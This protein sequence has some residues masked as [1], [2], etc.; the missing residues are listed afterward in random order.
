M[1]E[2][3]RTLDV[4]VKELRRQQAVGMGGLMDLNDPK[5][6]RIRYVVDLEALAAAID[7]DEAQRQAE[8]NDE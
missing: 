2:R 3:S 4:I 6:A 7:A 1:T 5:Q 8:E